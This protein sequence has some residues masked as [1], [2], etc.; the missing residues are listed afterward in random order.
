MKV[1]G[2]AGDRKS[3]PGQ[4]VAVVDAWAPHNKNVHLTGA[5]S[6]EFPESG[7]Y[8]GPCKGFEPGLCLVILG[9]GVKLAPQDFG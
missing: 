6:R 3:V 1:V 7:T 2:N 5:K 9:G 8:L 4:C